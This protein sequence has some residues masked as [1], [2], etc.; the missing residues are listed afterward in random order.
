M[1]VLIARQ[2][3]GRGEGSSWRN[4]FEGWTR[5][6]GTGGPASRPLLRGQEEQVEEADEEI[7]EGGRGNGSRYGAAEGNVASG[8][9]VLPS[10]LQ[11]ERNEWQDV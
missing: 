4:V 11:P 3:A 6:K 1:S 8:P 9:R 5:G 2:N 10:G 7:G